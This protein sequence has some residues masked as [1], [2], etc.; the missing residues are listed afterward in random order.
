MSLSTESSNSKNLQ[1]NSHLLDDSSSAKDG[2]RTYRDHDTISNGT[3]TTGNDNGTINGSSPALNTTNTRLSPDLPPRPVAI[4]GMA[5]RLPGGLESPQELWDFLLSKGD[6]RGE[7]P[8]SRYNIDAFH[9]ASGRPGT[10]ATRYGYFLEENVDLG[11]LD[12]SR[13]SLSRAELEFADPQQRR[14]LEVV[15][16]A[17]D[18][19]GEIDFKSKKIGCYMGSY[20]EDWLEMQNRDH[21]QTGINR[22][23]G[24]SDFML[25]SRISYEMDLKGPCMTIRTACSAALICVNEAFQALQ[26]GLCD[27]AVIGGSNLIMAPGMTAFMTEKGVL[28][29]DGS[30]KTFSADANGYAR[31]EAITAVFIKPLDAAIRDGNPIRAV[32]RNIVSNS[33]GKTQG[34][35]KPSTESQEALMRKAYRDAG[36]S[37]Y[38]QTAFVECHGT[39]TPVGD[40][41]E[42][43]AV[44]NVFGDAGVYIGSIKPNL[45]HSEGASGLTSLIKAVLALENRTIPPNIKFT[46]G[47]R[48]IPFKERKLTVPL[49]PT[50]W[51]EDRLD[52]VSVNSF[53]IGGSNAHAILEAAQAHGVPQQ[54]T[55]CDQPLLEARHRL[56]LFSAASR[57]SLQSMTSQFRQWMEKNLDKIDELAY[58]LAKRREHL[59]YRS[60]MVASP[61]KIPDV[62][63]Q[64][65]RV[66]NAA[67]SLVMVFTGQGAQWPRMGR[68]LL[69]R[70]DLVF[71][72]SIRALDS[73]LGLLPDAPEWTIE[74]ELLKVARKSRVQNAELSQPLCTAV[75][76]GLV[77]L[78]K[79]LGAQ[80]YAVVGHSSGEVAAAYAAGALTAREAI[81]VAWQRGLAA[82]QQ[83]RA[84]AMAAIGLGRA[85]VEKFLSKP[86]VVIACENSPRSVTI[87]GDADAIEATLQQIHEQLPSTT[88]RLLKVDKAYHSYHMTEVGELYTSALRKYIPNLFEDTSSRKVP[89][90]GSGRRV[91]FFSSVSG[92]EEPT[93]PSDLRGTYWQQNLESP[94]L[95]RS[96]IN[97]VLKQV[98]NIAFLEIGPH[99]A[100]AGPVRQTMAESALKGAVPYFG[101]MARGENCA[102]TFLASVG[103]LFELNVPVELDRLVPKTTAL[104]GLPHYPWDHAAS[105]WRESRISHEWRYRQFLAHPLLGIRQLES[106]TLEPSFRNMLVVE[107]TPWLRDHCIEGNVIFPCAGYIAMIGEGIRQISASQPDKQVHIKSFSIRNMILNSALLLREDLAVEI[108]TTFR[109]VR[110]TDSLDSTWWQWTIASYTGRLWIKHCSGEV[111]SSNMKQELAPVT[112]LLPRKVKHRKYYEI[113][114][115]AGIEYGPKFQR[116]SDIRTGTMECLS[117]ASLDSNIC[118]DEEHYF[119]HPTIIDGCIQSG[120][121]AATRGNIDEKHYRRVPTKID[122]IVVHRIDSG[123]ELATTAC[124][125]F[126][127]GSGEVTSRIQ[128]IGNGKVVLDMQGAVLS[129]LEADAGAEADAELGP[130]NETEEQAFVVAVKS[131]TED[132][133]TSR[134]T[135][136]PHIDFL[137]ARNLVRPEVP[138]HLYTPMLDEMARLCFI[139]TQRR[140]KLIKES[141]RLKDT[142]PEHMGK[143]MEWINLQVQAEQDNTLTGLHD[144][145]AHDRIAALVRKMKDTPVEDCA[146]AL[147]KVLINIENLF[148]GSTDALEMLLADNTLTK[149]YIATDACDRSEFIR[150]LAH[151]KPNLR[152]LE[153]GAGTGASTASMLK[154]L[155]LPVGHPLYSKYTFTDISAGFFVAAKERF[156]GYANLEYRILDIS[157]DPKEQGFEEDEKYDLIVATNVLHATRSLQQTLRNVCSLLDHRDGRLLLQELDSFSKWPNYI[158]GTLPGWWYGASDGRPNEPY[159]SPERWQ[160]E[161]KEA[162]FDGLDAVIRDAEQPHQLNAIMV[163]RV[164]PRVRCKKEVILLYQDDE[165]LATEMALQL[166]ERGYG[167]TRLRLGD[168]LPEKTQD[169][170]SLV[171]TVHPIFEDV[172]SGRLTAFQRAVEWLGHFG[173]GMLWVTHLCQVECKDP[174]F[175]QIIGTARTVRTESLVDLATCEVDDIQ[176]SLSTILDVYE[177]F[178][179]RPRVVD[180]LG[181]GNALDLRP[182]YEYAIVNGTVRVGRMY[183][184]SLKEELAK[185]LKQAMEHDT[186]HE[187]PRVALDMA[188]PGRLN[189]LHW[190]STDGDNGKAL[191]PDQVEVKIFAAGLNF[192]DVLSALGVIPFPEAGLGLEGSGIISRVGIDVV[193]LQPGDRVMFLADGSFASHVTTPAKLCEKIPTN[194]SYEDAASVPAVFS[195]AFASLFNIGQLKK[196]QT[197][198]IHSA[199]GGVGL[200][201]VQLARMVGAD[202]FA[203]VGNDDKADFLVQKFGLPRSHIFCSRDASFV[204]GLMRETSGK[205]V[206]LVLNSLSGELL[207]ATWR[208]VAEFGQLVEIGKRD[209]IDGGKL[210]MDVF[211]G[212]RSYS[213]FYLDA[214]MAKRHDVVKDL[215]HAIVTHYEQGLISSLSPVEAFAISSIQDGFRRLQQGTHIGKIVISVR[216]PDGSLKLDTNRAIKNPKAQLKLDPSASYLLI[217]GLGGLGRSV[218]RYLVYHG[219]RSLLFLSRS[220]GSGVEDGEIIRE[221]ESMGSKVQLIKGSVV[222]E[223]DVVA[224]VHQATNLKGIIQASMVLRD[225]N[226]TRMNLEQWNQAVNPKVQGTWNLHNATINAGVKLDFFVLFSSMSGITGQAGQANYAGANTFLDSFVQFRAGLQ[227]ACSALDIGAVQDVGYVSQDEAL[228]KRM[229]AAS[230]HGITE[231]ELM[232]ALSAA[233]LLRE[234]VISGNTSGAEEFIDNQTIGL[235]LSLNV[236]LG[237]KNSRAFWRKDRRMAVYHN[238]SSKASVGGAAATTGSDWLKNFLLRARSE[239]ALLKLDES[240]N[241]L[242]IEIGKKLFEFLLK[243]AEDVNTSVPLSQLG[244]DSLVGVEMRSWWRQAFGFDISVLELLGMGTLGELGRHAAKGLLKLFGD[245]SYEV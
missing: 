37:D 62:A 157:R 11:S 14:M 25:S 33:D 4:C 104:P 149:I 3:S 171:D 42:A 222:S 201:A 221:L 197:V 127:K 54:A 155:I 78:F 105:Y 226:F 176:S 172:D 204:K 230:A 214:E 93:Q 225:E 169:I 153:I 46:E 6:A 166:K 88:A 224:A 122:R 134:F 70:E 162:G 244:M 43:N 7:V 116:L 202:I 241:L 191:K 55:A 64:G 67:P 206:D 209:F 49:E 158:F 195:T 231:S 102:E 97:A 128:C 210:D 77:D 151:S 10:I 72:N 13:F 79:S 106:T 196:G 175:A 240:T 229:K 145:K 192:K 234:S 24:Y 177:R 92:A 160:K 53:G 51:P 156:K 152:I 235:G 181:E 26:N 98:P 185:P 143:Y 198:L 1:Q 2:H 132:V 50:P 223:E 85:D 189:T 150:H 139:L 94:V 228:L 101:A 220:A 142:L 19:A 30:C 161:L 45:G 138:R 174:R 205:G 203:T 137:A 227:L 86:S 215:L 199:A 40:P 41:I 60:F 148:A 83:V 133:F 245:D 22:A 76:I 123:D 109:P 238:K 239:T 35:A 165:S 27:G 29:P 15:R 243:S 208:C 39:G 129:P 179:A 141:G 219:A 91:L 183:P 173:G 23:D 180:E 36:I 216:R 135:W 71:Q 118:G 112:T 194:L 136:A 113:L 66:G 213:C 217:G 56:M 31:G 154:H 144:T 75:Q 232:E 187:E 80:P 237:N 242:A 120:P 52:R 159:V 90:A 81:I 68:E 57:S 108:V 121:V 167:S 119:L 212:S 188:K 89:G 65:R 207:H 59:T 218:A 69:M 47:N 178:R 168:A 100:L 74:D 184:F 20:G 16:E 110:L 147:E 146:A 164:K 8:K 18:D 190:M 96:A 87:S 103:Q 44:A 107:D 95:F 58:T 111:T 61:G 82:K 99:P 163:A 117:S 21:Q 28:S 9:A 130:V 38:S 126:L 63:S 73:Y 32:I 170:I 17:F 140:L 131:L 5:L 236:S 48:D 124:S 233:I 114:R 211:L 182:D 125:S 200:A 115:R 34:I 193:D 186:S 12:V 84:G